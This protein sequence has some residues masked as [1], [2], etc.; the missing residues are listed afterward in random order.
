MI[1]ILNRYGIP[2][3]HRDYIPLKHQ[4]DVLCEDPLSQPFVPE[5]QL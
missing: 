2:E 5:E 1:T 3:G 4:D